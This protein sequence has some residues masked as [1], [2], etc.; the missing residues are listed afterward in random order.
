VADRDPTRV[1][2][3]QRYAS[4]TQETVA[5]I[6]ARDLAV[7]GY[8]T[9]A[10]TLITIAA[11]HAGYEWIAVGVGYIA[12]AAALLS[13]HHDIIIGQLGLF[14]HKL[15]QGGDVANWFS[16]ENFDATLKARHIRD[17]YFLFLIVVGEIIGL[18]IS[19]GPMVGH[20]LP[21]RAWGQRIRI[22]IWTLSVISAVLS[23]AA[24]YYSYR[25]RRK[26]HRHMQDHRILEPTVSQLS[27]GASA[28]ASAGPPDGDAG[29]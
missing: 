19:F 24:I 5:R 27:V 11:S 17:Y 26:L 21:P 7:A 28:S 13:C 22:A 3:N 10:G 29:G 16:S 15:C 23:V 6:Q 18:A 8:V 4:A 12:L 2:A 14:Q 9:F 20:N 25:E 1:D